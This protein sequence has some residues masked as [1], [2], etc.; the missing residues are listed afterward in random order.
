MAR[1]HAALVAASFM[2]ACGGSPPEATTPPV[3]SAP[4]EVPEV[5]RE[6]LAAAPAVKPQVDFGKGAGSL[7]TE[8]EAKKENICLPPATFVKRLCSSVYPD[9][10][11]AMFQKSTP[12]TRGYLKVNV[13]AWNASGGLTASDKLVFDEEVLV[14]VHRKASDK[15]IQLSGSGVSY[16]VLRWDGTCASLNG[17]E[18]TLRAPP[19][20]AKSAKIPWKNLD[21]SIRAA[22][23]ANHKV[24]K[25]LDDRK[26]ECGGDA[27]DAAK[28][29]KADEQVSLVVVDYV[30]GGGAIPAPARL[31]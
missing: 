3:A 30:R 31:P 21:G 29:A 24:V 19:A 10:A 27:P 17:E 4:T 9:V 12:W 15:G 18:L 25:A 1:W 26:K 28:C 13:E 11:L 14:L 20:K 23:E 16:D 22:L 6:E 5:P 7:P 2:S 8:C